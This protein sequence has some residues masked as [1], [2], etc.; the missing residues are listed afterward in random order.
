[1]RI[2]NVLM[3]VVFLAFAAFQY[4]DP[5]ALLWIVLYGGA[6]ALALGAG[7][8]ARISLLVLAFLV[9]TAGVLRLAPELFQIGWADSEEL[10]ECTGL[11]IA[12]VWMG[13]LL[14]VARRARLTLGAVPS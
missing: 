6:A 13:V 12:A 2:V 14:L 1:M 11:F 4:N 7:G 8:R 10:R 9:Y 3:S 5:D